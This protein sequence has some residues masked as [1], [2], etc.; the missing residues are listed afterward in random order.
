MVLIGPVAA[1]IL[2]GA[3]SGLFGFGGQERANRVNQSEAAKNRAFQSEEAGINREFQERMRNTEWQAAVADMEAAGINPAVAY[4][5]GG[6]SSPGGSMA[7]GS[8]AAPAGN[9]ASSAM[10]AMQMR[11]TLAMMDAQVSKEEGLAKQADAEGRIAQTRANYLANTNLRVNGANVPP[12]IHRLFDAELETAELGAQNIRA[13]IRRTNELGSIAG[14][15]GGLYQRAA[16]TLF[17]VLDSLL[18]AGGAAGQ[19]IL[20]R[21]RK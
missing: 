2:G 11:K 19:R 14:F 6:A 3:I 10:Q 9:S 7:S 12:L 4:S 5:K 13:Q 15:K 16:D 17:P 20:R 21:M 18:N 1:G 8:Q